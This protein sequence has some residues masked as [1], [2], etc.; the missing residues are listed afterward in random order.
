MAMPH[1]IEDEAVATEA[2]DIGTLLKENAA[3][4]EE[5]ASL[6]DRLLRA[7]AEAENTR[8]QASRTAEE[9]RRFAIADFAREL[10]IVIDNLQRT[11][12][13]ADSQGPST[14]ENAT[15]I[16]G[17]QATLRVLL[18]T[19]ERFGVRGIQAL[20]QRFDPNLHEA[21]ME[22]DD[23]AQAP[24]TVTQVMEDGYTIHGR[25]L[26]PARVVVSK[27]RVP[28]EPEFE[29]NDLGSGWAAGSETGAD[30]S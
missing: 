7:L 4:L 15:L 19:L 12:D 9:A 18:Q 2:V 30:E 10:L 25:L 16:E 5:K 22:V 20:G 29:D 28:A 8:R 23:P 14:R 6:Q 17:V 26:R 11:I 13:A 27:R 1:S 24:G 3:L 21:V